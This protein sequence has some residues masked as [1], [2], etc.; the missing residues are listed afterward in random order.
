M[1]TRVQRLESMQGVPDIGVIGGTPSPD[2]LASTKAELEAMR[3]LVNH[4]HSEHTKI[5]SQLASGAYLPPGLVEQ[6]A[7]LSATSEI[8]QKRLAGSASVVVDMLVYGS[9]SDILKHL[10]PALARPDFNLGTFTCL[11]TVCLLYTSDAADE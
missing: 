9:P 4:V 2:A 5:V 1:D 8:H 7:E 10:G 3:N 6:V 11:A